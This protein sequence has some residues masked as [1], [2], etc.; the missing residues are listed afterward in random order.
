VVSPELHRWSRTP[1]WNNLR[2]LSDQTG[3][4]LCTD[5]PEEAR[6]FFGQA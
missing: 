4:M 5:Y 3:L 6:Q 2:A 1:L